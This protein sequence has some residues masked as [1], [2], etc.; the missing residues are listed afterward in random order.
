MLKI[1]I[2]NKDSEIRYDNL[3]PSEMRYSG[4]GDN[5]TIMIVSDC[6]KMRDND[7]VKLESR[8]DESYY[9]ILQNVNI[10]DGDT[11]TIPKLEDVVCEIDN[12]EKLSID[13]KILPTQSG[14]TDVFPNVYRKLGISVTFQSEHFYRKNKDYR[15][16]D[17]IDEYYYQGDIEEAKRC[18]G[19]FVWFNGFV[20]DATVLEDGHYL[21][22]DTLKN[23]CGAVLEFVLDNIK[24]T[25]NDGIVP[26]LTDASDDA[27]QLI[28]FYKTGDSLEDTEYNKALDKLAKNFADITVTYP[29]PRFF[30][31]VVVENE[32]GVTDTLLYLKDIVSDGI[33]SSIY[34]ETGHYHI[35]LPFGEDF[36]IDQNKDELLEENY[37]DKVKTESINDIVDNERRQFVPMYCDANDFHEND[38]TRDSVLKPVNKITFNLHFRKRTNVYGSDGS[39]LKEWV[40]EDEL[41]WNNYGVDENG[42]LCPSEIFPKDKIGFDKSTFDNH[43]D[44]LGHLNFTDDDIYYQKSKI[45]KSFIRLSFYDSRDRATQSLLF[46]STIFLDSGKLYTKYVN[47]KLNGNS[48]GSLVTNEQIN[49]YGGIND[50]LRLSAQF[51][52]SN[53]YDMGACSEGFYIYLHPDIINGA[54]TSYIYMKVEFNH[55]KYGRIVPFTM[56]TFDYAD[57]ESWKFGRKRNRPIKSD[58]EISWNNK[59]IKPFPVHYLLVDGEGENAI[60][61]GIN[62]KRLF[63]DTY[64]KIALKYNYKLNQYCWFLP[65]VKDALNGSEMIF[66]LFEPRINGFEPVEREITTEGGD[67]SDNSD[68]QNGYNVTCYIQATNELPDESVINVKFSIDDN[69]LYNANIVKDQKDTR[70][71]T[72]KVPYNATSLKCT[73]STYGCTAQTTREYLYKI[74]VYNGNDLWN[75][76]QHIKGVMNGYVQKEQDIPISRL[77]FSY[78]GGKVM[79]IYLQVKEWNQ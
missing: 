5:E 29:D 42:D 2:N 58:T 7:V 6:H 16:A 38:I 55:A 68:D 30:N 3:N 73:A 47:A 18:D 24:Y 15:I 63:S 77:L 54:A 64:I 36:A 43:A 76:G 74:V 61:S 41:A 14:T 34:K 53:K 27:F 13:Y 17:F 10:I 48:G 52:C 21:L 4:N 69:V 78:N 45:K 59:A 67:G 44:L 12:V 33:T 20:F 35:M 39:I 8:S 22:G 79:R 71:Y 62:T 25:L 19:D 9:Y 56:P 66:N 57:G 28:F 40:S 49:E 1:Q 11:F 37:L 65:R 50:N 60:I 26:I 23:N 75:D 70:E 31:T 51:S 72:I 32:S 46:Y